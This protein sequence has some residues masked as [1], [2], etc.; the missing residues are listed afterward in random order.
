[1]H[2]VILRDDD[3]NATTPPELLEALYRPW[4]SH[5]MPVHL[6]TI[7]EVRSDTRRLDGELEGFLLGP[8]R[9]EPTSVPVAENA[10]LLDYLAHEPSYRIAQHGYRH[11]R[12]DGCFEF[13]RDA[14]A[15]LVDRIA[16]GA[17]RLQEAGLGRP[18]VFVAPQD[19]LSRTAL[20]EV[21]RR[22][23]VVS[24]GWF[25]LANV[26]RRA[27][28]RFVLDKKLL[29]RSHYRL[30]GATWLTHPGCILSYNRDPAGIVAELQRQVRSR[31][32]TVVVSHHWEYFANGARNEPLIEA[33][34]EFS[35]WVAAA[36]DVRAVRFDDAPG[37]LG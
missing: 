18:S 16:R 14:R 11:E 22:F 35:A 25:S 37:L 6:A 32:L 13:D 26:P 34:H 5:G 30:C 36:P 9:G 15:D 10:A 17:A 31:A 29:Q 7:P 20:R 12:V 28:P 23:D 27:W 1:M 4:L 21:S 2:H 19:R 3:A 8:R 24:T 33:L